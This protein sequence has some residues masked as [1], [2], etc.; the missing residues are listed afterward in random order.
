MP[1]YDIPLSLIPPWWYNNINRLRCTSGNVL[2]YNLFRV[3][4]CLEYQNIFLSMTKS[5]AV[6]SLRVRAEDYQIIYF[7]VMKL[8]DCP[9]YYITIGS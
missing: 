8:E 1:Q 3:D 9:F 5:N 4:Y 7:N 6:K 2:I